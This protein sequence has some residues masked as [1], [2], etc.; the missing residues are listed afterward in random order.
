MNAMQKTSTSQPQND[1]DQM[2][3]LKVPKLKLKLSKPYEEPVESEQSSSESDSGSDNENE[4][5]D[6]ENA[7]AMSTEMNSH[8]H[9]NQHDQ[10]MPSTEYAFLSDQQQQEQQQHLQQHDQYAYDANNSLLDVS[11]R[12]AENA[13][14]SG[15]S[16][17]NTS[18]D[19]TDDKITQ[20]AD[21]QY[22]AHFEN[23]ASVLPLAPHHPNDG[24]ATFTDIA[25]QRNLTVDTNN[26][27][28]SNVSFFPLHPNRI[29]ISESI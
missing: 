27:A 7:S 18:T 17:K 14:E 10:T 4:N 1:E 21:D 13:N 8:D 24:S 5:D 6:E 11:D 28:N 23:D 3:M 20:H 26:M 2:P 22:P 15:S 29:Q 16:A 25:E 12:F 19:S 9:L